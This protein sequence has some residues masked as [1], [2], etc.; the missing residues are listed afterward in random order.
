MTALPFAIT[1]DGIVEHGFRRASLD[2]R[3]AESLFSLY[4]L[5]PIKPGTK[6][7]DGSAW[8][9]N[10]LP[11]ARYTGQGLGVICGPLPNG[12]YLGALDLDF[13]TPQIAEA[14]KQGVIGYLLGLPDDGDILIRTGMPPKFLIPFYSS[15]PVAG[16]KAV[17]LYEPKAKQISDNMQRL[18]VL[19]TGNQ[20]LAYAVHPDTGKPYSWRAAHGFLGDALH[21]VPPESLTRLT[22][23]DIQHIADMVER[24]AKEHGLIEKQTDVGKES[25]S[26]EPGSG[27][28]FFAKVNRKAI[29]NPEWFPALFPTAKPYHDGFRVASTDLGRNLE[30]DISFA[31]GGIK[32]FGEET[33]KTAIDLVLEWGPATSALEAALWLC[34]RIGINPAVL[35]YTDGANGTGSAAG[36]FESLPDLSHPADATA[37]A[38]QLPKP[39]LLSV[40][41]M[42]VM[43]AQPEPVRF[44]VR[45]WMPCR[46]VTLLGG[47]GGIGKSSLALGIAAHVACGRY[48]ADLEVTR[49]PVVF[50]SLEDEPAIVRLR[51]RKVIEAYQLPAQ[52][53]LENM[54]LLDGT[55]AAAALMIE[56]DRPGLAPAFTRAFHELSEAADGA[57]LIIIDN[58]SDAFAANE[59]ARREVR[60]FIRG[61]AA[62][63][64]LHDAALVLLAHIDKSSA[65]DGA[66]GNSYSG[67]T[68]WH[69]SA[70]SRLALIEQ[71]GHIVLLHEK[72]NLSKKADPVEIIFRDDVP[73]PEKT[74]DGDGLTQGDFDQVE[75]MRMIK[76]ATEGGITVPASVTPGAHCAMK[77]LENLQE[78]PSSLRGSKGSK[79]AAQAIVALM[80][81]GRIKEV[82]Y[83]N[84][85]RKLRKRLE[86]AQSI[87][88]EDD[89]IG[90]SGKGEKCAAPPPYTP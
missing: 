29:A 27:D 60:L 41:L 21:Q 9:D 44:A 30:E 58:A 68:A 55:E 54:R 80:R 61:L 2:Q 62:I 70:R 3:D 17:G 32:D 76:L 28:S 45:P 12:G 82:E 71:D 39:S 50:V 79:R 83:R 87:G 18:E 36:G 16:K 75:I 23:H 8:Q 88:A 66:R 46:H 40:D 86:L 33:G 67:S 47:H 51:L 65:K 31:N 85:N 14:I 56:G 19:G 20:F 78:Y 22:E 10:P 74:P 77:V 81:N 89:L 52:M 11:L 59:N 15:E 42:D 49:S 6:R 25:N 26:V 34:E 53:V 24:I 4:N 43:D 13:K 1:A 5:C 48:F 90:P 72:A 64:R 84:E 38:I 69:N 7:P 63:A 73:V 57:G 35:G 37:P